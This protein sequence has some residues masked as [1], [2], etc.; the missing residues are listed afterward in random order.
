MGQDGASLILVMLFMAVTSSGASEQIALSSLVSY[1]V[2]RTYIN[3]NCSGQQVIFL[4]RVVILVFGLIMGGLGIAF[5]HIGVNLDF[6]YKAMGVFIGPAVVPVAYSISWGRCSARGAVIGAWT[7]LIC[8]VS[9]W[10]AYGASLP[11]GVT[12]KNLKEDEVM[13]AGN[14]TSILSSALVCTVLSIIKPDDCDWSTTKAIPLIEDDPNAHIAFETEEALEQALKKIGVIGLVVAFVLMILWPA[15][16]LPARVFS[17][18]YFR[19]WVIISF[20][21]GITSCILMV[22]L[23]L[24]ESRHGILT[25]LSGG[26]LGL[27][28]KAE[29]EDVGL[30]DFVVEER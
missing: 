29:D 30:Q 28:N 9:V 6:L 22:I 19:F 3:P 5:H 7:G 14:L 21:W 27:A 8:G 16:S 13:L 15:L 23:P 12:I 4:S 24:V 25:L 18:N 20:V 10:F 26:R 1:D 11:G 17:Q 2:Y